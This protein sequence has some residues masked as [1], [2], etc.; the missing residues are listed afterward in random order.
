MTARCYGVTRSRNTQTQ[1]RRGLSRGY[2][3]TRGP[4][5]A[6]TCANPGGAGEQKPVGVVRNARNTVTG[7]Y[8]RGFWCYASDRARVTA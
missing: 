2:A 8:W 6:R 4:V 1:Q 7:Q 5:C 3:V